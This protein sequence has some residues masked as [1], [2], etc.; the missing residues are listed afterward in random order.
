L[1][2]IC[3]SLWLIAPAVAQ[4]RRATGSYKVYFD[5]SDA[6]ENYVSEWYTDKA[7]FDIAD[8]VS[9]TSGIDAVHSPAIIPA[10]I[11]AT[12]PNG[13]EIWAV[14]SA[15]N[16]TWTWTKTIANVKVEYSTDRGTGWPTELIAPLGGSATSPG[17][18]SHLDYSDWGPEGPPFV[19]ERERNLAP[20]QADDQI[21][22][23]GPEEPGF[24]CLLE[25]TLIPKLE[26]R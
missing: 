10:T 21:S 9:V 13:C 16:V 23:P 6:A 24:R 1:F 26:I 11:E 5:S 20:R 14:G 8:A 17:E 2:I 25:K 22:L 18:V 7:D 19:Y 4:Q 15:H 3:L 12:S